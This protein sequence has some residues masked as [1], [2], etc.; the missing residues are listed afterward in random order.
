MEPEFSFSRLQE[1]V[2]CPYHE[3]DK[4]S[5]GPPPLPAIRLPQEP[6]YRVLLLLRYYHVHAK[7]KLYNN[8]R[9]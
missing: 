3:P 4:S 5:P 6:S 2:T 8:L 9:G 7:K 1:P